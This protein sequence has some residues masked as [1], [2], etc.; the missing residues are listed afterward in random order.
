MY[1]TIDLTSY[2]NLIDSKHAVFNLSGWLGGYGQEDDH[3]IVSVVFK[4]YNSKNVGNKIQIGPVYSN[5]R[6]NTNGLVFRTEIGVVPGDSRSMTVSVQMIW[7]DGN[8]NDASADN[9]RVDIQCNT[10]IC[11]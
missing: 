7:R 9:I 3:S 2:A 10:F 11:A 4:N 8:L 5:A 6:N 1:Q